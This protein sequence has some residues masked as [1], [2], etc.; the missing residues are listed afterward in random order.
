MILDVGPHTSAALTDLVNKAKTVLWNGP[1][2]LYEHG[3]TDGTH[4][5]A[6]A[7][8]G[9]SAHSVVGG[10]DTV[11]AIDE[12]GLSDHIS[13]VSTGGGAMLD[14]LAY[15]TLPGLAALR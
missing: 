2:G 13:F 14:Y 1:L 12:L 10:G 15:G 6:R 5:L 3:F 4:G 9:S 7:I 8:A 11:A